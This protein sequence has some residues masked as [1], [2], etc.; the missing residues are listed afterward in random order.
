MAV[1]WTEPPMVFEISLQAMT[2][3]RHFEKIQVDSFL[4]AV[5][6]PNSITI[7]GKC[8]NM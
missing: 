4:L 7:E 3:Q 5:I 2:H 1:E 8:P 6:S